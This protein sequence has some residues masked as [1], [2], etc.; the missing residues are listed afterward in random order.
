MP[1]L[2]SILLERF[3]KQLTLCRLACTIEALKNYE[4]TARHYY[5]DVDSF[6]VK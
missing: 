6:R 2:C 1:N 4:F 3:H 5:V